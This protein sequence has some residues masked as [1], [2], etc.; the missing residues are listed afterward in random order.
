MI[1]LI[2]LSASCQTIGAYINK[3]LTATGISRRDYFFYMCITILPIAPFIKIVSRQEAVL[4][5]IVHCFGT[6]L[7]YS[8]MIA[9][10]KF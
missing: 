9:L 5:S 4:R 10:I 3:T 8:P 6:N 2:L 7:N 1:L